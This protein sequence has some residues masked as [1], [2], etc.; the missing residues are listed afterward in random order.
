MRV[1]FATDPSP[2]RE[3]EDFVAA[4]PNVVVL[5]DGAGIPET[6]DTGCVHGVPWFVR[7]LGTDLHTRAAEQRAS[8]TEC[9]ADAIHHVTQLHSSVCDLNNPM[10]PSATVVLA[11]AR[12]ASFE[13][14]VLGDS[15]ILINDAAGLRA[16]SD[17]RVSEVTKRQREA[18]AAELQGMRSADRRRTLAHA[19]RSVMN[20]AHG[21]WVAATDPKAADE[22]LAGSAPVAEVRAAALL[23]DGA[24]RPV[25]DFRSMTWPEALA[26][27]ETEGPR[28]LID[29]TRAMERTDPDAKR[30]PRSKRHDDATAALLQL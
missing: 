27:L 17:H 28:G 29:R 8:L 23:T 26:H 20:T 22:S 30:W 5:L 9:L 14:L 16:I 10:T 6:L 11:R 2:G 18:M 15:T 25:D 19:Q 21:Y 7:R 1:S 24:A 12:E 13:W 3:N 4:S